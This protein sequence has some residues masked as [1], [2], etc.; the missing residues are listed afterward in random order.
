MFV[1]VGV[2]G[3]ERETTEGNWRKTLTQS[4]FSYQT[5]N[6]RQEDSKQAKQLV[7]SHPCLILAPNK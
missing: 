1:C 3:R 4:A 7:E 5:I 2:G 6:G